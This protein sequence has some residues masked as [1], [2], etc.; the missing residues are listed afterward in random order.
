MLI[1]PQ[2]ERQEQFLKNGVGMGSSEQIEGFKSETILLI[3]SVSSRVKEC[4]VFVTCVVLSK[5]L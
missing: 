2:K 1:I 4:K 5:M 3:I